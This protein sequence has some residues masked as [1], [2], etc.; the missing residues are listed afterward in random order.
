MEDTQIVSLVEGDKQA[1][2]VVGCCGL[3]QSES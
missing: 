2:D 1:H 3:P